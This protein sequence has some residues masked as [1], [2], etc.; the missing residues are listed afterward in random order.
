MLDI[1][2]TTTAEIIIAAIVPRRLK[3]FKLREANKLELFLW[4]GGEAACSP[5]LIEL[6]SVVKEH[7]APQPA[8]CCRTNHNRCGSATRY[9][10]TPDY[11]VGVFNELIYSLLCGRA[12]TCPRLPRTRQ[13]PSLFLVSP[14]LVE[15]AR[16]RF[17]EVWLNVLKWPPDCVPGASS[18]LFSGLLTK[19]QVVWLVCLLQQLWDER[20][21]YSGW[22]WDVKDQTITVT[23]IHLCGVI[24]YETYF[25]LQYPFW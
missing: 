9:A 12:I 11:T 21:K 20:Q 17:S 10:C 8:E 6:Y 15:E 19:Q 24:F 25:T 22:K 14:H 2:I 5:D 1:I 16:P 18:V 3:S 13:L 23:F 4:K 7:F